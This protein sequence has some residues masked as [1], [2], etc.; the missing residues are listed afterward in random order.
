MIGVSAIANFVVSAYLYRQARATESPALEGD[1]AHL[2][3]DA[4]TSLGVLV[5]LV[6]LEVTG[7]EWIDAVAAL[8]SRWRS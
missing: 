3:T 2:R 1:A 8:V 5:G 7:V 4:V 6:L